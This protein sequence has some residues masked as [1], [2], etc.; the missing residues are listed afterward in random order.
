V[1]DT[2]SP[3][4]MRRSRVQSTWAL[5]EREEPVRFLIRDHDRTFTHS[6]DT[7]FESDNTRIPRTPIQVPEANGFAERF[8]RTARAECLDWLLNLNAL[9]LERALTVFIGTTTA[10]SPRLGSVAAERS[11]RSAQPAG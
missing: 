10:A 5:S 6:F 7:V 2:C 1:R 4:C 8:V 9:H 3:R 11:P